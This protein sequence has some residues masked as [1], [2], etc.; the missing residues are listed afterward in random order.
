[1]SIFFCAN[2]ERVDFQDP[3]NLVK[4]EY[5]SAFARKEL[6]PYI[7]SEVCSLDMIHAVASMR[8][9]YYRDRLVLK[10]GLSVRNHVPLLNHRFSFDAD[11]DPNTQLKYTF[12]DEDDIRRDLLDFGSKRGCGISVDVT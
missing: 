4:D 5:S 3:T 9:G 8:D 1:M 10:G 2:D 11:Y 7:L 6:A 12:G